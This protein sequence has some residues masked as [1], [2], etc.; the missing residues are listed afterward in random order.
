MVGLWL[1]HG[2]N[3]SCGP[4]LPGQ[5]RRGGGY[6]MAEPAGNRLISDLENESGRPVRGGHFVFHSARHVPHIP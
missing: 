1:D 4:A 5:A 3:L 6:V 2:A